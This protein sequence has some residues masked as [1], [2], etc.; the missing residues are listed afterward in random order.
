MNYL[1]QEKCIVLS[2]GESG[3]DCGLLF[4]F[5][6]FSFPTIPASSLEGPF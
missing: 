3:D 2:G 4:C 5:I 6:F 1:N